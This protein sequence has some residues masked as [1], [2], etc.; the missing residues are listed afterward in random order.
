MA[1]SEDERAEIEALV[2]EQLQARDRQLEV[3]AEVARVLEDGRRRPHLDGSPADEGQPLVVP[4]GRLTRWLGFPP[5]APLS[6]LALGALFCCSAFDVAAHLAPEPYTYPR[7][8][9]WLLVLALLT[10]LVSIATGVVD[11]WRLDP[12]GQPA[13][14]SRRHQVVVYLA[15][16]LSVLSLVLRRQTDF[17]DEV[18]VGIVAISLVSLALLLF[19]SAL[20][21]RLTAT[22]APAHEVEG[23]PPLPADDPDGPVPPS[24]SSQVEGPDDR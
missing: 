13:E 6:A 12:D 2:D 22:P 9:Y 1:L 20:G 8:S 10:S 19:G 16:G 11:H 14:A 5:H 7:S 23:H 18:P 21:S 4:T 24:P 3:R 15:L 17:I